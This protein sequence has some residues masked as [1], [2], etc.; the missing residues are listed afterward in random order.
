MIYADHA[1]TTALSPAARAAMEPFWCGS[2]GNPSAIYSVG[3]QAR[4]ALE[5]ARACVANCIGAQPDELFFTSGGSESNNTALRGVLT[6][7][8][9]PRR[10]IY[11]ALE[12]TSVVQCA[13]AW[14]ETVNGCAAVVPSDPDGLIRPEALAQMLADDARRAL[15]SVMTANNE[16]GTIQPI[17]A[18]AQLTHAHGGLFHTDA[19]QAVGQ[20]PI[21]VRQTGVDLLSASG[22]KFHAPKGSGFLYVRRGTPIRPLICG[23]GQERGLRAGTEN[24]AFAVGLAAA[25]AEC[26]AAMDANARRMAMLRDRLWAQLQDIPGIA[27]NGA[28]QPRLPGNLDICLAG[29]NGEGLVTLLDLRGI[30]VSAGSACCAHHGSASGSSPVLRAIGRSDA[31]AAASLRITVGPENT[32]AEMDEISAALHELCT[33]LRE[34]G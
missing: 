8:D 20:L 6:H 15:V 19:V 31:E 13:Q 9:A 25:L 2:F 7:P 4:Q 17:A 18:L 1:A 14:A 11:S 10:L 21:D 28:A 33:A 3:V 32:E 24:V 5:D 30:C 23:G 29:L 26:C 16:I 27:R 22:H 12:H 34:N